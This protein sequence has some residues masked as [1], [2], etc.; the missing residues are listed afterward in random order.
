MNPKFQTFLYGLGAFAV[1]MALTAIFIWI[2]GKMPENQILLGIY[3]KDNLLL[4]LAVAVV[5]TFSHE[6]KKRIGK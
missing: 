5:L 2:S 4:G 1:Y 6:R 3:T